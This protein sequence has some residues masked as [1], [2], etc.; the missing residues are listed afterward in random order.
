ML[1]L[2]RGIE[3][4]NANT[5]NGLLKYLTAISINVHMGCFDKHPQ[6]F[7]YVLLSSVHAASCLPGPYCL[8][9]CR[10]W[11]VGLLQ[12]IS[13]DNSTSY[14]GGWYNLY[15]LVKLV[16]QFVLVVP[17]SAFQTKPLLHESV[18]AWTGYYSAPPNPA[19][20]PPNIF[21]SLRSGALPSIM[22]RTDAP[23]LTMPRTKSSNVMSS[24]PSSPTSLSHKALSPIPASTPLRDI[25]K[26]G[27]NEG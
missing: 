26:S 7:P 12:K 19:Q 8:S 16:T 3:K 18:S 5:R 24:N 6:A 14:N 21:K 11:L 23:V 17:T 20:Q 15:M 9:L 4:V 22:Q 10:M 1:G 13:K 2:A 27:Q 25:T